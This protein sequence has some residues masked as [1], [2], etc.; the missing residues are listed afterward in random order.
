M[1]LRWCAETGAQPIPATPE[2]VVA[3]LAWMA[4]MGRKSSTA[5]RAVL[6]IGLM[7]EEMGHA[8]PTKT[9]VVRAAAQDY[10]RRMGCAKTKKTALRKRD[11]LNI[12]QEM[13]K[14]NLSSALN[15][16][17][18]SLIS[19]GFSGTFRRSELAALKVSDVTFSD[20]GAIIT[21]LPIAL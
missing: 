17:D 16:R 7:H 18:W 15:T 13:Q 20:E 6:S 19:L 10:R 1:F 5:N 4:S 9:L 2:T 12:F 8:N 3:Y 14:N 21:R 11:L